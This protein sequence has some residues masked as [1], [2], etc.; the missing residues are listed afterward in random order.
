MVYIIY[1]KCICKLCGLDMH[2]RR[3]NACEDLENNTH[4][5][6]YILHMSRVIKITAHVHGFIGTQ[7]CNC[8][9][10]YNGMS[11]AHMH[12]KYCIQAMSYVAM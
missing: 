4:M 1:V 5:D 7:V 3:G 8:T 11:Q 10:E 12:V 2:T 9:L 6:Y